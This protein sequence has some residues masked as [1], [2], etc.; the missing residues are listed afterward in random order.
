VYDLMAAYNPA[1]VE[2]HKSILEHIGG[3]GLAPEGV[4]VDLG[5]GTGEYSLAL[6]RRC[7]GWKVVHVE[8]DAAMNTIAEKKARGQNVTN[9]ELREACAGESLFKPRSIDLCVC[10]HA[11]YAMPNP[12]D[13]IGWVHSWLR[14]GGCFVLCDLGRK[15]DV[16]EWRRFIIKSMIG[17]LGL[18]RTARCLWTGRQVTRQNRLIAER[19]SN[20]FYWTH[21]LQELRNDGTAAGFVV[22][23]AT[24]CYR[25]KSDLIIARRPSG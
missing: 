10:V 11:L 8:P 21:T 13:V 22:S 4:A 2:L 3:L 1:F 9:V 19:Q 7:P 16:G 14:P 25:G 23:Y 18:Y 20:G 17:E 12:R 15:L 5:A 6:A 24:E